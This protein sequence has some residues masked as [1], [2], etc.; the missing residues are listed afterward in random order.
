MLIIANPGQDTVLTIR[1]AMLGGRWSGIA[2]AAGIASGQGVWTVAASAGLAAMLMASDSL[3]LTIRLV[4]AAYLILLGA[5]SLWAARR[6]VTAAGPLIAVRDP[7]VGVGAAFRWGLLSSLGN[8]MIA[9]FFTSLLP[10]FLP[11]SAPQFAGMVL[12]GLVFVAMN[13]SWLSG[14]AVVTAQARRVLL[15]EAA[16]RAI[17]AV[18]G[19]FLVAFGVRLLTLEVP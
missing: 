11:S 6:L 10:Q 12:L 2:C 18:S 19:L 15:G 1:S 16:W 3:F 8:P 9:I 14:Y 4:G 17:N 7:R 13:L 5:R